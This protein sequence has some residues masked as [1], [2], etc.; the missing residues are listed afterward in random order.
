MIRRPPR[1][2]LFPYTTLFRSLPP[3]ASEP[4]GSPSGGF[5]RIASH[6]RDR[7]DHSAGM[8]RQLLKA[9]AAIE[10]RSLLIDRVEH[11]KAAADDFDSGQRATRYL[12]TLSQICIHFWDK[13]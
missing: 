13:K 11:K 4:P 10:R 12:A 7:D 6:L 1:S 8:A 3:R 2:T 5:L 9:D